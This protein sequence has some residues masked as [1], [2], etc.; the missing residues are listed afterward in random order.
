MA[1]QMAV[2][3]SPAESSR[4]GSDKT[5]RG[6]G[7]RQLKD[8]ELIAWH[9]IFFEALISKKTPMEVLQELSLSK[10][11]FKQF[12]VSWSMTKIRQNFIK[13]SNPNPTANVPNFSWSI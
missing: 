3:A 11:R 13:S 10:D 2:P 7:P 4:P 1:A 6:P 12:P 8:R 9:Q 5:K